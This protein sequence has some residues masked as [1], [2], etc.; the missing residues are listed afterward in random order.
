V[1]GVEVLNVICVYASQ[2]G[3]ADDIKR[4]FW[5]EWKKSY[6]LYLKVRKSSWEEIVM[7]I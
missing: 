7:V 3:L 2:V 4:V 6:R 5:E 1:A